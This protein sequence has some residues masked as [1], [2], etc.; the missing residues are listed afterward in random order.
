MTKKK[1]PHLENLPKYM[2]IWGL[3]PPFKYPAK[4]KTV[5]HSLNPLSS[6]YHDLSTYA[7]R[8]TLTKMKCSWITDDLIS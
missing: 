8:E 2:R 7:T 3:F 1:Q 4:G 5:I 6:A